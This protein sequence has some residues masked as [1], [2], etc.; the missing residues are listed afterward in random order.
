M[1]FVGNYNW[2]VIIYNHRVRDR[3]YI[4]VG[5]YLVKRAVGRWKLVIVVI[6]VLFFLFSSFGFSFLSVFIFSVAIARFI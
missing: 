5:G 4:F 2:L 1:Y 6:V 3:G